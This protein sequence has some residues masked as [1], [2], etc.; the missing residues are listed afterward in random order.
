M[1]NQRCNGMGVRPHVDLH[2]NKYAAVIITF[3]VVRGTKQI[4]FC[5]DGRVSYL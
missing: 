2:F 3:L 5:A 4:Y 1:S